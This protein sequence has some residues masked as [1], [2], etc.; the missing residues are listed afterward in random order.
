MEDKRYFYAEIDSENI[1]VNLADSPCETDNPMM[2]SIETYD[3]SLLGKKYENGEW[4]EVPQP[5]TPEEPTA[6]ELMDI[7]LGVTE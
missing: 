6:D 7:L 4:V 5:E 3:L 1:C 2:I